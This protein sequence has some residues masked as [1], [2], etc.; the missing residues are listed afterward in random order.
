MQHLHHDGISSTTPPAPMVEEEEE[1]AAAAV[2]HAQ[3]LGPYPLPAPNCTVLSSADGGHAGGGPASGGGR[4]P[5]DPAAQEELFVDAS[6]TSAVWRSLGGGL[7]GGGGIGG[8]GAG[9][10]GAITQAVRCRFPT[11]LEGWSSTRQGGEGAV[12]VDERR[13][14]RQRRRRGPWS[15]CILRHPDLVTVH[16]PRGDSHDVT[17]PCEARLLQPLGEGLLVQRYAGG[18]GGDG[19]EFSSAAAYGEEEEQEEDGLDPPFSVP[20]LFTLLHPLDELRPVA[21]LPPAASAGGSN[22]LGGGGGGGASSPAPPPAAEAA[23]QAEQQQQQRLVCDA[24]EHVVFARGGGDG[25]TGR[26]A[27]LLLTYHMGRRRHS[28]WLATPVPEPEKGPEPEEESESLLATA[29]GISVS[30]SMMV[31]QS[32]G[33]GVHSWAATPG[34]S[35]TRAVDTSSLSSTLLGVSAL[36]SPSSAAGVTMMDAVL[37]AGNP[38]RD[39]LSA[40]GSMG[41]GRLST[42]GGGG[43]GAGRRASS[44]SNTS[45]IGAGNTRNEALA[46]ALGLGQ[47]GLGVA[48]NMLSLSA[49]A[50]HHERA[51]GVDPFLLNASSSMALGGTVVH[52]EEEEDEEDE[53]QEEKEGAQPIRPHLGISLVWRE[54]EGSPAPAQHVFCA[55]GG[56]PGD[57]GDSD[58]G[59]VEVREAFSLPCRSAVGLC[60][61]GGGE[62]EGTPGAAISADILVLGLDGNLTLFRGG[63]PVTRVARPAVSALSGGAGNNGEPECISEAV[64]SCFTLTTRGGGRRRLRL[65]LDPSSP[66]VSACLGA[67]D[68]LLSAPLAASLRADIASAAHSLAGQEERPR[69]AGA[70][71]GTGSSGGGD[72][73]GGGGGEK[74]S[75]GG[76]D[77]DLDWA[78]LVSVLRDLVSGT[79]ESA[80]TSLSGRSEGLADRDGDGDDWEF[81][82]ASPFHDEFSRANAMMLSGF[83]HATEPTVK[84]QPRGDSLAFSSGQRQQQQHVLQTRR[85]DFLSEA[86]AVFDA[87]H[88]VLEDLKTS[89]FTTS[90][91]P[92]LASLLL[93]LTRVC[94]DGG[95]GMRDFADH[96]WRDAAGCGHGDG[97][98]TSMIDRSDGGAA[99]R[100]ET[101]AAGL[102]NRPTR[103]DKVP[104][105][106]SWVHARIRT[107]KVAKGADPAVGPL[108]VVRGPRYSGV[109][110]PFPTLP[111]ASGVLQATR[112]FCRFYTIICGGSDGG[113]VG[114]QQG[115]GR[116]TAPAAGAGGETGASFLGPGFRESDW[117]GAR[118]V[119]AMVEEG[120]RA[121]DLER[122][123]LGLTLPLL[124]VLHAASSQ[125]LVEWPAAAQELVG[126]QDL[127]ALRRMLGSFGDG[128]GGDGSGCEGEEEE[129]DDEEGDGF[130]ETEGY[131]TG[132]RISGS[133]AGARDATG[134]GAAKR[135]GGVALGQAGGGGSGGG[136]AAAAAA[137]AAAASPL[138]AGGDAA[139]LDGLAWVD[140]L[141]SL[142]FGRDQRVR[143]ACRLLR[144][145]RPVRFHVDRSP[146][147]SDHDHQQRQQ[148]R[149]LQLAMRTLA[150]PLGRGMLTLGTLAPL[151]AEPLPIPPL[152][153]A[154]RIRKPADVVVNLDLAAAAVPPDTTAWAEF[155]NGVAAG[156]R[157]QHEW[158]SNRARGGKDS[159]GGGGGAA[160]SSGFEEGGVS[161]TWITYN[162]PAGGANNAHGGLLMALG[163]QGHLSSLAMTDVFEYLTLGQESTTV[164]VLLGMAAAR[165]GSADLSTH[166]M[167]CLHVPSLL[168]HP[169]ADM[170]TSSVTQAAA[171]AG[172]GLLYQGTS[173]RLMTEFLLGEM[174]RAPCSDR[175]ADREGYALAC[176]LSLGMINLAKGA[177][178]GMAGVAD[179]KLEQQLH[180]SGDKALAARLAL[181]QTHFQLDYARPE[182]LLLRVVVKGLVMWDEVH[183]TDGW[184]ESQ[185]PE[186]VSVEYA[187]L[188]EPLPEELSSVVDRQT[189]RQAH[190]N[191]IAGGCLCLG[192]RFAGTADEQA[193]AT[194][195]SRV[196]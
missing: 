21:L 58:G 172:V 32:P 64:G 1:A 68:S 119:A 15:V 6:G 92:R 97:E 74:G 19:F 34:L 113:G 9:V 53:E 189:I 90:L 132:G 173:H 165:R 140:E 109:G 188:N 82:L 152:C 105:F 94:G 86:G 195:L 114:K 30:G 40:G 50:G 180:R 107:G 95:T 150:G 182:Q 47:S 120:Y 139:D 37:D 18:G 63:R 81:L 13:R 85:R 39:R 154:G 122:A 41:R 183:P 129:D 52:H 91:V 171:L 4:R 79:G 57:G 5:A 60:A 25:G 145:S 10:H 89:R 48:S 101:G 61:T 127:S 99:L 128:G 147:S 163:L 45:W 38:R 17:L 138:G 153:L 36:K 3:D 149:L 24:S 142:R 179:L 133:G 156:L 169:F 67:W 87:L 51:G 136:P 65:S 102:P 98:T 83:H 71:T 175:F 100:V 190:A 33:G 55:E 177:S 131:W 110:G 181:P 88:L 164:G 111:K 112:R 93:S 16:H 123:P 23:A 191:I 137:A 160:A 116:G 158:G 44:G 168:P 186:V 121:E 155:H 196:R 11:L 66:L 193:K 28:L 12:Q 162:R 62:A 151:L 96:Y 84:G 176:G 134:R 104:C 27:S 141:S 54:A 184:I 73:G 31:D 77:G 26:D 130:G 42:G 135:G 194:V 20:S 144:G 192:L 56:A 170:D 167:L 148:A 49:P 7:R 14:Q 59:G 35:S 124:E 125:A 159:G 126:R 78:A 174:G 80:H 72:G 161:R 8:A 70:G 76:V 157:L 46:S 103:F 143:E 117:V 187:R 69:E 146:E 115:T 185:I 178:G 22:E 29:G 43:G 166:K 108:P 118:L 106:R 75:K 2:V